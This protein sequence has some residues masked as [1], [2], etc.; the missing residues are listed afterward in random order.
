MEI[1]PSQ[2]LQ[3]RS[4]DAGAVSFPLARNAYSLQ[5]EDHLGRK[6]YII[7][8]ALTHFC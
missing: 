6:H 1:N 3:L 2:E 4:P 8:A 5:W 7:S